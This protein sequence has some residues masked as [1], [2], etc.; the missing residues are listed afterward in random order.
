VP[1]VDRPAIRRQLAVSGAVLA[2]LA[3]S[4]LADHV[5]RG[6]IVADHNLNPEWNHSGW[7]FTEDITPFTPSL[8]IPIVF[9]A[10]AL[11][12]LRGHL[13]ARFWLV[14]PSIAAAV[15]VFVHFVPG[16]QTETL[17][18]IYRTYDRGVGNPV[19]GAVAAGGVLLIV[20]GL[21]VLIGMAVRARRRDGSATLPSA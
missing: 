20:T 11:L 1:G 7:P 16:A 5:I 9:L 6:E 4:H 10:G 14:W 8:L 21:T 15:V 3:A 17:G 13:W 12:T 19:A 18:V 2:V